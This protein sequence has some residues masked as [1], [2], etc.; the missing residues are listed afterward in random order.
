MGG[1]TASAAPIQ[2]HVAQPVA[3]LEYICCRDGRVTKGMISLREE[4]IFKIGRD[5]ASK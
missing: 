5:P 3:R 1:N 4:D 2:T